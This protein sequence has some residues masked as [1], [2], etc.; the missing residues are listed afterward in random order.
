MLIDFSGKI[1]KGVDDLIKN[2]PSVVVKETYLKPTV[3]YYSE[4]TKYY[5]LGKLYEKN[6]LKFVKLM[7]FRNSY[8]NEV[9]IIAKEI[10]K[11]YPNATEAE[12]STKLFSYIMFLANKSLEIDIDLHFLEQ[13]IDILLKSFNDRAVKKIKIFVEGIKIEEEP[14][15][16]IY[17]LYNQMILRKP[18]ER[19]FELEMK[20]SIENVNKLEEEFKQVFKNCSAIIEMEYS[21]DDL[22]N[23]GV[24]IYP[25]NVEHILDILRLFRLGSPYCIKSELSNKYFKDNYTTMPYTHY[26][27]NQRY[28][29]IFLDDS[30]FLKNFIMNMYPIT[31]KNFTFSLTKPVPGFNY[32]DVA[33]K[34]YKDALFEYAG[35]G[36]DDD[37]RRD[38]VIMLAIA[39]TITSLESLYS[40]DNHSVSK[41][42]RERTAQLLSFIGFDYVTVEKDI[43]IAYDIRSKVYHGE[44]LSFKD[45]HLNYFE[46]RDV[47]KPITP[48]E[49]LKVIL[50]Y[51][52]ISVI[53]F[54]YMSQTKKEDILEY[55]DKSMFIN[56]YFIIKNLINNM[57]IPVNHYDQSYLY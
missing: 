27:P 19:D 18:H 38:S 7:D 40:I 4:P 43:K 25:E 35:I 39:S 50:E 53:I 45:N 31:P 6:E 28:Y 8:S 1:L 23:N 33:Y 47:N 44:R 3:R 16:K 37:R 2:D 15:D 36:K 26:S 20:C 54:S 34:F 24:F 48:L 42:L 12:L 9:S 21:I 46:N 30:S 14:S 56:H 5:S 55:I 13:Q 57:T 11:Y 22:Y 29:G 51:N 32:L 41:K 52:R 10:L 17:H 49:F